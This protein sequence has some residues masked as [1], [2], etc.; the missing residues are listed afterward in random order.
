MRGHSWRLPW[1]AAAAAAAAVLLGRSAALATIQFESAT[2]SVAEGAGTLTIRLTRTGDLESPQDYTVGL[3]AGTATNDSRTSLTR[4]DTS[5]RGRPG[6]PRSTTR[7]ASSTI[8]W[9]SPTRR[10][11]SI[12]PRA[13]TATSR[14]RQRNDGHDPGRRG[15]PAASDP[16]HRTA[17]RLLALC[18]V[19]RGV[20]SGMRARLEAARGAGR[21]ARRSTSAST[22]ACA[23]RTW[24][25]RRGGRY[26]IELYDTHTREM[27]DIC[28]P[29]RRPSP[30]C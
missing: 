1:I 3:N 9:T 17:P 2:Y 24:L 8:R 20:P 6:R 18:P 16:R 25:G 11:A 12:S 15:R 13:P 30:P 22:S 5:S 10:S 7:S 14:E 29:A 21:S 28:A 27:T 26:F 19:A 4:R 23:T